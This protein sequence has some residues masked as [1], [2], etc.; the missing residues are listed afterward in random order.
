M[1]SRRALLGLGAV[2]LGSVA[3][4]CSRA[5]R[6]PDQATSSAETSPTG[7]RTGT[8]SLGSS[9]PAARPT[10]RAPAVEIAHGTRTR[11][12]V[13]LTF[14]GAGDPQI[15]RDL[16]AIFAAHAA[17]V[18][19]LAVGS[20]LAANPSIAREILTGG[21]DVGNHTYNHL[22]IDSLDAASARAGDRALSR[23]AA[24]AGRLR[25][26]LLP[27]LPDAARHDAGAAACRRRR[28]SG[29]LVV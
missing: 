20:W 19:V 1:V 11:M 13:A 12:E 21:H 23:R 17:K 29:V 26:G 16:L 14:H 9:R 7:S 22:D 18:T 3:A 15:A 10:A 5:T 6:G 24:D 4:A 8:S 28:V 25:R 2:A 27:T